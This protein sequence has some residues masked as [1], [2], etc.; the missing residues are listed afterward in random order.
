MTQSSKTSIAVQWDS[1]TVPVGQENAGGI[2]GYKLTVTDPLNGTSWEAFDGVSLGTPAQT[3]AIMNNL[4]T[5]R[6]YLFEVAAYNFNGIGVLSSSQRLYSCILP[7]SFSAPVR[8]GSTTSSIDIS[9]EPPGDNGGCQSTG[10]AVFVDDG[11]G[12]GT[13]VEANEDNDTA[14][15]N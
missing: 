14:L 11:T 4:I 9:W 3:F 1:V 5:G 12:S 13:F 15:R 10:F 7:T 2:L 6:D 8:T